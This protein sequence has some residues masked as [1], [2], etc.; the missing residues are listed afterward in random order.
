MLPISIYLTPPYIVVT[1]TASI[2]NV[3]LGNNSS[4]TFG[5]IEQ[6]NYYNP[7]NYAVGNRVLYPQPVN[8]PVVIIND[9]QYSLIDE[10]K[11]ILVEPD[12]APA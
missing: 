8:D 6:I 11:I 12:Q 2:Y 1:Q 10:S 4:L 7:S 3:G 5:Y 9:V